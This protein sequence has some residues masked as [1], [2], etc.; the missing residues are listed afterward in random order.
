MQWEHFEHESDIGVRGVGA[1]AAEAFAAAATA[2]TAVVTDPARVE[3]REMVEITCQADDLDMLLLE[4]LDAVIYEMDTRRMLFSRFDV[5]IDGGR[6]AARA[7]G[8]PVDRARHEPAVEVKAATLCGLAVR[9][10]QDGMWV[11]ECVVD[12]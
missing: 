6:L 12:V 8:E 3:P 5:S 1:T 11:A 7:W 9:R 2:V 10:R 4:W